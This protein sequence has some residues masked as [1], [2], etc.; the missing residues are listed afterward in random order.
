MR[1]ESRVVLPLD[2]LA[3][4]DELLPE[5]PAF[6]YADKTFRQYEGALPSVAAKPEVTKAELTDYEIV[7]LRG[8]HDGLG[9]LCED[10][11]ADNAA[12]L[13]R[14]GLAFGVQLEYS[15]P[16]D[17]FY[18]CSCLAFDLPGIGDSCKETGG[19]RRSV[20]F[21]PDTEEFRFGP[22]TEDRDRVRPI[23]WEFYLAASKGS[24]ADL[25]MLLAKGANP[26]GP[27]YNDLNDDCY[28]IH[29]AACNPDL[30]VLKFLVS[31]GV[32]P[33][34]CDYWC[35]QPLGHA[36]KENSLEIVQW[37]VEHGNDP[38]WVD[39]EGHSVLGEAAL[40]PDIRVIEYLLEKGAEID[41]AADACT[42]LARALSQGTPERMKFFMDRG[43]SLKRAMDASCAWA[44][45][46]NIRFALDSGYDPNTF[47]RDEYPGG[48]R[49]KVM[50]HLDAK[51]QALFREYGG[52]IY[53]EDAEKY[54]EE[55]AP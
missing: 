43:A 42:E 38:T 8:A 16:K 7:E 45:F 24:V 41:S 14:A 21:N 46:E 29:E 52:K 1:R 10:P 2:R 34:L 22:A 18:P 4:E 37:L 15:K 5:I 11:F 20:F 50:D 31:L 25:K 17:G 53:W 54:N 49:A 51:R 12:P 3:R 40:N 13:N 6:T 44:P 19:L 36:V 23:D 39:W 27:V 30:E 48:Q 33:C 55:E 47:E 32:N 26:N 28:A 35:A 9:V